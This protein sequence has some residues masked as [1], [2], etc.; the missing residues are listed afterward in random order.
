MRLLLLAPP[1]AGKGTQARR[2]SQHYGIE[3]ISTGDLLRRQVAAATPL[4]QQARPYVERG[5]LVP[6]ELL[7]E[8]VVKTV[9]EADRKGGF[10]LD[11]Y[12]RTLAQAEEARNLARDHG[13][14]IDAAVYLEV[15][16][17]EL[18][19]RLLGRAT[20]E[21]RSDDDRATIRHRLDVFEERTRPLLDY[22]KERGLLVTVDGEQPVEK[23][24][25]DMIDQLPPG[26]GGSGPG[27]G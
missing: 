8:M 9:T 11:G 2:L 27:P 20:T 17:E 6:D 22:F 23:V 14:S 24:T 10:V 13:I 26:A 15:R 18:E 1:G 25:R 19:R 4:G 7:R 16:P 5:D 3:N 21:G 12:P